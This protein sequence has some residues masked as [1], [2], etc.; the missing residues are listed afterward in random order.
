MPS[1]DPKPELT[2]KASMAQPVSQPAV[3]ASGLIYVLKAVPWFRLSPLLRKN[4]KQNREAFHNFGT[5]I[6]ALWEIKKP[7]R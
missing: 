2:A 3:Y 5:G 6:Y 1:T 7:S 4:E